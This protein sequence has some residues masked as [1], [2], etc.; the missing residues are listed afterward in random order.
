MKTTSKTLVP[1]FAMAML[2]SAPSA[3]ASDIY[4]AKTVERREATP[5]ERREANTVVPHTSTPVPL[6]P[7]AKAVVPRSST[8]VPLGPPATVIGPGTISPAQVHQGGTQPHLFTPQERAAM[9]RNDVAAGRTHASMSAGRTAG[10]AEVQASHKHHPHLRD[11]NKHPEHNGALGHH[12][13]H[14]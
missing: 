11:V 5:V 12:P 10:V 13:V 1:I 6:G 9:H 7:P 14:N 2:G 3:E 8:P 4:T